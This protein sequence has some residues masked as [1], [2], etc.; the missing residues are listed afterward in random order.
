[1]TKTQRKSLMEV[2]D[3]SFPNEEEN[4]IEWLFDN[5]YS[6]EEITKFENMS[7][8]GKLMFMQKHNLKGHIYYH[9]MNLKTI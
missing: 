9:L 1:M 8:G 2:I 7:F 6:D 5:G 3:Y 4:F